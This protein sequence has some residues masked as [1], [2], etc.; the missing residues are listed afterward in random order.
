[1]SS[2]SENNQRLDLY[3]ELNDI[4]SAMKNLAQVELH[5]IARAESGQLAAYQICQGA[6][7]A[8]TG[9]GAANL[10]AGTE[11]CILLGSERGFCGGFNEQLMRELPPP[12]AGRS[13]VLSGARLASKLAAPRADITPLAAPATSD[14][15]LPCARRLLHFLQAQQPR[16]ICLLQHQGHGVEMLTL[17]PLPV[18][19]ATCAA[20]TYMPTAQL[21]NELQAHY[22]LHALT[23]ALFSALKTENRLRLQQMDAARDHLQQLS[24]QLLLRMNVLRQQEIVDEIEVILAGQDLAEPEPAPTF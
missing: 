5:R 15:V 4:V 24:Q 12:Q 8:V 7:Q 9:T 14:E 6:L 18:V 3:Q 2:R 16:R 21:H 11:V 22:L 13:M 20:R 19:P 23:H 17:W 1:M 10:G